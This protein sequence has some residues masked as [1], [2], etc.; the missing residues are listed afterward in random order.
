M[1]KKHP[2]QK[3]ELIHFCY[4][5]ITSSEGSRSR[6]KTSG[7]KMCLVSSGMKG[8]SK[9]LDFIISVTEAC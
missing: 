6:N 5:D 2:R 3:E 4:S 8:Q 1:G 9:D 7:T